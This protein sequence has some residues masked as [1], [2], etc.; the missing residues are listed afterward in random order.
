LQIDILIHTGPTVNVILLV[1]SAGS[2]FFL[3]FLYCSGLHILFFAGNGFE[4]ALWCNNRIFLLKPAR[5]VG[6]FHKIFEKLHLTNTNFHFIVIGTVR[7]SGLV[8]DK[9][10]GLKIYQL[11][12]DAP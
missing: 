10:F 6:F 3:V 5:Q 8:E 11:M 12:A 2:W 9:Q 7:L 1:N 4:A